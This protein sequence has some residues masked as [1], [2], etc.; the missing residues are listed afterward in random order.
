MERSNTVRAALFAVLG[1]ILALLSGCATI[2]FDYPRTV[3]SALYRPEETRMGRMIQPRVARHQGASGFHFLTTGVDA[4]LARVHLIDTAEKTLDLQYYIFHT[5]LTGKFL[6]DRIVAAA[7]RGVRV[8]LLL[9]DFPQTMEAD[10]WLAMAE[11]HSNLEVRVFNP[12][13]GLRRT[14]LNRPVQLVLGPK[15]LQRRMHNK[16]FIADNNVTIVGGRNIADEYFGASSE[17]NFRDLDIMGV[18]PVA[19]EISAVFD[20]YWNCVLSVPLKALVRHRPDSDDLRVAR[21]DLQLERAALKNSTYGVK[22]EESNFLKQVEEGRLPLVWAPAEVLFDEPMKSVGADDSKSAVKMAHRLRTLIEEAQS[23]VLL[24]SPYF[25]PRR[26]G[27][28]WFEKLRQRG[29]PVKIITNSLASTDVAV[30]HFGYARYRRDLLRLGVELYEI[31][32]M[33]GK[34]RDRE[35]DEHRLGGSSGSSQGSL[36]AKAL[37]LDRRLVFVGS[38]NHDPRSARLNTENGIVIRSPELAEQAAALFAR[39]SAPSRAYRVALREGGDGLVWITEDNGAEVRYYREPDRGFWRRIPSRVL[40]L[41]TP[42]L[43]L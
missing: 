30:A 3:S 18:G 13:G 5:D 36:H 37:V 25:V 1:L 33:V 40:S 11:I 24:I 26:A 16:A 27:V 22:I 12:F 28:R 29:V 42:E 14:P 35:E 15:R 4:F 23:E 38:F 43:M 8:R 34:F 9:D 19:R 10:W 21:R 2:P 31:R 39:R 20:D 17:V 32:P 6:M 7:E 41:F